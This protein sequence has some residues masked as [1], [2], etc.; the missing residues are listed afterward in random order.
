MNAPVNALAADDYGNLY[1]GGIF[2]LAGGVPAGNIAKW[3]GNTWSAMGAGVG[4]GILGLVCDASGRLFAGGSFGT[5][6]GGVTYKHIAKWNGS[7]WSTLGSGMN[8]NV[9]VLACNGMKQLYAGGVFTTAGTNVSAYLARAELPS[10]SRVII[11]SSNKFSVSNGE[12]TSI[13]KGTDFGFL[14]RGEVRTNWFSVANGGTM[15]LSI[16]SLTTNGTGSLAFRVDNLPLEVAAGS[17]SLFSASFAPPSGLTYTCVVAI[18]N[19]SDQTPYRLCF[20]GV[21]SR[22]EQTVIFDPI[23]D[24]FVTNK[25]RLIAT[26]SS[27][28]PVSFA[29]ISGPGVIT[30]E[31]NLS[32]TGTGMVSVVAMQAGDSDWNPATEITNTFQVLGVYSLSV[33]TDHGTVARN[34]DKQLYDHGTQV[35]LTAI[36]DPYY[37]FTGW[38]GDIPNDHIFSNPLN[39]L[40]QTPLS[41]LARFAADTTAGEIPHWWLAKHNLDTNAAGEA[42]DD[43]DGV[44][45]WQEY[46]ANT[47]PTNPRSFFHVAVLSNLPPWTVYFDSASNR[48]YTL[49]C[50]TNLAVGPWVPLTPSN[51]TGGG[52]PFSLNDTQPSGSNRFWRVRVRLPP[53]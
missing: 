2:T 21:G 33:G 3:D 18:A 41:V 5:T 46:I 25:I 44:P 26:S 1:A 47:D 28:L 4:G 10:E 16:T 49:E 8:N 27:G 19:N 48:E 6:S 40:I 20:S 11:L 42:H 12:S 45:V 17:S 23:Q 14:A 51:I 38:S 50:T 7:A 9:N 29:L 31:T 32:F 36:P 43:G 37:H 15:A 30:S 53:E 13:T 39:L 34:P 35:T 24:Q 22:W 52:G